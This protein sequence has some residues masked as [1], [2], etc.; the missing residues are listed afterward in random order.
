MI[1]CRT[2]T[3]RQST[4]H[5]NPVN[6]I[7]NNY[8]IEDCNKYDKKLISRL[9]N[10]YQYLFFNEEQNLTC[11][12][13]IQHEIKVSD[14]KPIFQRAYKCPHTQKE[15]LNKQIKDLVNKE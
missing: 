4:Q 11:S 9:L 6:N 10:K 7:N 14:N 2:T 8:N 1:K 15:E 3:I 5:K 12:N 13:Q